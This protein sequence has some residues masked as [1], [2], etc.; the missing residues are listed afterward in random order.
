MAEQAWPSLS[1]PPSA[2]LTCPH[3]CNLGQ[4]LKG[5]EPHWCTARRFFR[6]NLIRAINKQKRKSSLCS[7]RRK[8]RGSSTCNLVI[9]PALPPA[10]AASLWGSLGDGARRPKGGAGVVSG[11]GPRQAPGP[12]SA[13][14]LLWPLWPFG[15]L[16]VPNCFLPRGLCT[17]VPSP[18]LFLCSSHGC[19][20][21]RCR[22]QVQRH[23]LRGALSDCPPGLT[24]P[25]APSFAFPFS[26]CIPVGSPGA[27]G[28]AC[29]SASLPALSAGR[30]GLCRRLHCRVPA[31][32][33]PLTQSSCV[34]ILLAELGGV[35]GAL[36]VGT[37]IRM[38]WVPS[39]WESPLRTWEPLN[40]PLFPHWGPAVQRGGCTCPNAR[41]KLVAE[42][43]LDPRA[44]W[45]SSFARTSSPHQLCRGG[46]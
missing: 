10:P 41:G 3:C 34:S 8:G 39:S 7:S 19:S 4:G 16:K 24:L 42:L 22:P 32:A 2:C 28:L 20:V 1:Q 13:L 35:Q 14:T 37:G 31:L 23:L 46:F 21:S 12:H 6:D 29:T 38:G 17:A 9:P 27:R 30:R 11:P 33:S 40:A 45:G 25:G 15:C 36:V 18:A 5:A 26:E 44:L 43:G